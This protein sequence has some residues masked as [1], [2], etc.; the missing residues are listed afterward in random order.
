MKQIQQPEKY[1]HVDTDLALLDPSVKK[2]SS[3]IV[4]VLI[5]LLILAVLSLGYFFNIRRFISQRKVN[6][7]I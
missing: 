1:Q 5:I 4:I 3:N 7:T 6:P 2:E